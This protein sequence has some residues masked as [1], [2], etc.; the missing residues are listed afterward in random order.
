MGCQLNV[1]QWDWRE[2][3]VSIECRT[4]G[5]ESVGCQLNVEQWDW[6]VCIDKEHLPDSIHPSFIPQPASSVS[7]L[8]SIYSFDLQKSI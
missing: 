5:L 7:S 1:A 4:V 6:R 8:T 2:C 3:G